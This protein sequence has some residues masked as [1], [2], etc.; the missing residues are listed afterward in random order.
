MRVDLKDAVR[1]LLK[2][3][4][5]DFFVSRPKQQVCLPLRALTS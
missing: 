2:K 1:A 5:P 4:H 3:V